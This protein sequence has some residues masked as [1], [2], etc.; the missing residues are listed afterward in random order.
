MVQ[1]GV[2]VH[3]YSFRSSRSSTA[4]GGSQRQAGEDRSHPAAAATLAAGLRPGV[5]NQAERPLFL[6]RISEYLE[7][8]WV[9]LQGG[10]A[11]AAWAEACL[12]WLLP[13]AAGWVPL[14]C[15]VRWGG[16]CPQAVGYRH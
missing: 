7:A 14:R 9:L 5:L 10:M 13:H 3:N 6:P 8:R 11:G 12:G 4:T 1:Q 16:C 2:R 15:R